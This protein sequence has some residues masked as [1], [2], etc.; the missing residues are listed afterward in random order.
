MNIATIY[1]LRKVSSLPQTLKTLLPSLA[2]SDVS[3]GLLEQP[4][5]ILTL[6]KWLQQNP[7]SCY[8]YKLLDLAS[9][10]FAEA[11]FLGVVVVSVDRFLALHLHLR[12]QELVAH[13]RVVVAVMSV[14]MQ[15]AFFS[16]LA[17]SRFIFIQSVISFVVGFIGLFKQQ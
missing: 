3:V 9:I 4:L 15:S 13:R 14:W 7:P 10:L 6:I 11:S 8:I 17:F 12:Y 2:V 16:F 1:A 5:Y